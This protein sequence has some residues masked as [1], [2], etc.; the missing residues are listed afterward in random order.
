VCTSIRQQGAWVLVCALTSSSSYICVRVCLCVFAFRCVR[1]C[2]YVFVC[3]CVCVPPGVFVCVCACVC[4]HGGKG[5]QGP[6]HNLHEQQQI[7]K[8]AKGGKHSLVRK[9]KREGD[10]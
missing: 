10:M 4:V 5:V 6:R 1:L 8:R 7:Q 2:V 3:V 9:Q